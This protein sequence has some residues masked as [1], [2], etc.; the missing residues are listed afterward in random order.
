MVSRI[1]VHSGTISLLVLLSA[2]GHAKTIVILGGEGEGLTATAQVGRQIVKQ[3]KHKGKRESRLLYVLPRPGPVNRRAKR[4]ADKLMSKAHKDF[5]MMEYE[6][7]IASAEKALQIYKDLAKHG[8]RAGYVE[9]QHLIAAAAFFGG[10]SLEA[11]RAMNDAFLAQAQPP[12]RRFSPQIQ[13]LYK[14]V[15]GQVSAGTVRLGSTPPGALVWF[16]GK[17]IGPAEGSVRIRAGLYLVRGFLPGHKP[18]QRWFRVHPDQTRDLLIKLRKDGT[19]ESDTMTA[20]REEASGEEPGSTLSQ[21]A[22]DAGAT[23]T[24]LL[25]SAKSCRSTR[26]RITA[27]WVR[28]GRWWQRRTGVFTGAN[29]EALATAL[30]GRRLPL[31]ASPAA[32]KP[33]PYAPVPPPVDRGYRACDLDSQCGI[34]EKCVGGRCQ[35]PSSIARKWWFWTL[36]GAGVAAVSVAIVVPLTRPE[37]PVINVE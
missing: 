16:H 29:A 35:A 17:L 20:L 4:A 14:Q 18:Y 21:V 6:K 34:N 28:E 26:C 13:D 8:K 37:A 3:L 1:L 23:E 9:A 19:P 22:L 30:V 7:A 5:Q 32:P 27:R 10:K 36:I 25:T 15:V 12:T 33:A 31:V 24:I 2:V 11:Q